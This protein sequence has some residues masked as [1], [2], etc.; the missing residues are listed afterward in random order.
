MISSILSWCVCA[1]MGS[2]VQ[3][4]G[5]HLDWHHG[6]P[7]LLDPFRDWAIVFFNLKLCAYKSRC[8]G[9]VPEGGGQQLLA[10]PKQGTE[11]CLST[12]HQFIKCSYLWSNA[13][14]LFSFFTPTIHHPVFIVSDQILGM[15]GRATSTDQRKSTDNIKLAPTCT[16]NPQKEPSWKSWKDIKTHSQSYINTYTYSVYYVP[17]IFT[18]FFTKLLPGKNFSL[19]FLWI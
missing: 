14:P 3:S 19:K 4:L 1:L 7:L 12:K 15:V 8:M 11:W 16:C 6:F 5:N 10:P 17:M 9:T 18:E 2:V 13:D